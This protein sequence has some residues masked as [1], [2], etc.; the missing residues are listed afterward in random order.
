[1]QRPSLMPHPVSCLLL[2]EFE[3][4]CCVL[5]VAASKNSLNLNIKPFCSA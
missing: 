3:C 1:M 4:C 2:F 5:P